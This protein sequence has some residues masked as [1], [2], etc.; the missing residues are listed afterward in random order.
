M[1]RFL[2]DYQIHTHG[3]LTRAVDIKLV[4]VTPLSTVQDWREKEPLFAL[5]SSV[6]TAA[7]RLPIAHFAV[8]AAKAFVWTNEGHHHERVDP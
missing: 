3:I 4:I 2:T 5:Q 1:V 7:G 6:L 8:A